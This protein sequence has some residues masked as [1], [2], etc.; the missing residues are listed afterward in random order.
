METQES[1]AGV[2][3]NRGPDV[4][5]FVLVI[6]LILP[7]LTLT[8]LSCE[9]LLWERR[10]DKGNNLIFAEDYLHWVPLKRAVSRKNRQPLV[11][12]LRD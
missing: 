7:R 9:I 5:V 11:L 10:I 4:C 6:A 2:V 3:A 8:Q 1:S 12:G